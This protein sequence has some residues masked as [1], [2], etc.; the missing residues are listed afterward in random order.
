LYLKWKGR[1][2]SSTTNDDVGMVFPVLLPLNS[3]F[4]ILIK[5]KLSGTDNGETF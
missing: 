4:W 5:V 2:E 3:P 1:D